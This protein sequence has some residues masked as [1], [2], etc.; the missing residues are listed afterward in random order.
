MKLLESFVYELR[1]IVEFQ[2]CISS[3]NDGQTER[4]NQVLEDM[5]RMSVMDKLCKWEDYLHLVEFDYNN[6]F[7]SFCRYESIQNLIWA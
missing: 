7:S 1:N 3:A 2:Y 5:L 6:Y 4:V